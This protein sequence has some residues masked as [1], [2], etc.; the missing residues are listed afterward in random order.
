LTLK[1]TPHYQSGGDIKLDTELE[2]AGLGAQSFNNVPELT[3]RSFKGNITVREGEPSV[4]GGSI[5]DQE[6]R[7]TQG[8]PG[9]GQLPGISAV[10]NKNSKDHAHNEILFVVTPYVIRKPFHDRGASAFWNLN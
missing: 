8:Y 1:V 7:S 6:Q 4:I 3:T 2:I 10:L 9:I 5:T